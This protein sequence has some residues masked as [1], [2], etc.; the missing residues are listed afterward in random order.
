MNGGVARCVGDGDRARHSFLLGG[1]DADDGQGVHRQA[2]LQHHFP[3]RPRAGR[4][5]AS[6]LPLA[7]LIGPSF[8]VR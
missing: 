3:P 8:H 1:K 2:A 4:E 5:G 7:S 6:A